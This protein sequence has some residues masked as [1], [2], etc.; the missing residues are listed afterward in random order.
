MWSVATKSLVSTCAGHTELVRAV[1]AMPDGQRILSGGCR[2]HRPRVAPQRHPR[3]HLRAAHPHGWTPSWR[4]PTT[5]TRSPLSDTTVKLFNVNDGAVLRTFFKHHGRRSVLPG[6]AA[7][8]PPLRQRLGRRT[9]RI[10]EHGLAPHSPISG[11]LSSP[12]TSAGRLTRMSLTAL[13]PLLRRR[14]RE[15]REPR[16][17]P[18]QILR[19][20][21]KRR[22]RADALRRAAAAAA[23]R[24]HRRR[25]T[26]SRL[27]ARGAVFADEGAEARGISSASRVTASA[28]ELAPGLR[29]DGARGG[30]RRHGRARAA[31]APRVP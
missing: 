22:L 31:C 9:A 26:P 4:C 19:H 11:G 21:R 15:L 14:P 28:A 13:S 20:L 2:Q 1:A 7:R 12:I 29:D 23:R 25:A 5:S 30:R 10:V 8:R 27:S 16:L 6:A 24:D 17:Q 3:E 18:L